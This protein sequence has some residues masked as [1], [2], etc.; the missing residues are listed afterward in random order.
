MTTGRINQ[1]ATP[2]PKACHGCSAC[3]LWVAK[4][5]PAKPDQTRTQKG[6]AQPGPPRSASSSTQPPPHPP[7]APAP[8]PHPSGPAPARRASPAPHTHTRSHP[9]HA[10][11][12]RCISPFNA[13]V[14]SGSH[15]LP[16][17]VQPSP[18]VRSCPPRSPP[19]VLQ[20]AQPF[21]QAAHPVSTLLSQI[22]HPG[23][24]S[25]PHKPLHPFTRAPWSP[26]APSQ[27]ALP[28]RTAPPPCMPPGRPV[29]AQLSAQQPASPRAKNKA[30]IHAQPPPHA[31]ARTVAHPCT[32]TS[33]LPHS[34]QHI[35]A[36]AHP[37]AQPPPQ[38]AAHPCTVPART[39]PGSLPHRHTATQ[40]PQARHIF[41]KGL[42]S[43]TIPNPS[44]RRAQQ[45]R[46]QPRAHCKGFSPSQPARTPSQ[47]PNPPRLG[48]GPFPKHPGM[49]FQGKN[50]FFRM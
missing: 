10:S 50:P 48:F 6:H 23:H 5:N 39:R 18:H 41:S 16:A 44:S 27:K 12:S 43:G 3:V 30:P 8:A 46:D 25:I 11:S 49:Q 32:A 31:A 38:R 4:G 9:A 17:C 29:P 24:P 20:R 33:R 45:Q 13:P 7:C 34:S 2:L 28:T 21:F 15:T 42:S 19:C 36:Q 47:P 14:S 1:V 40:D 22:H 35:A 37:T 26:S